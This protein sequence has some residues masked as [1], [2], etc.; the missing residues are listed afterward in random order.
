MC[1]VLAFEGLGRAILKLYYDAYR[2]YN[3]W[4]EDIVLCPRRCNGYSAD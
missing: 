1:L 3:R 4:W 2:I